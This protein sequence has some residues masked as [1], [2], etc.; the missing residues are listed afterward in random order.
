MNVAYVP[1]L[2]HH[3]LSLRRI[4]DAGNKYIG[5]REGIRIVFAKSGDELFAPSFGQLNGLFG[6]R[7]DRSSE[8]NLHAVIA[9]GARP[10]PSA[11]DI[12]EFHCSHG[13]MH[14][15]LLHKTAK[16]VG[17][18]LQGQLVPCQGCSEAKGIRKSVKPFTSTRATKPAKRCFVDLSGPK[19]VKSFRKIVKDDYSRF[20]RAFFLRTKDETATYFLKYLAEIAPRNVEVVRSDGGGEFSKGAFGAFC[21]TEKIRQDFTT[22][23][24]PQYNGVAKRQIAIIEAASLAARIQAGAKYPT[25]FFRAERVSGP[26]KLIGLVTH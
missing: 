1:G 20:T 24:S 14:E 12:N 17:V 21:T 23:D 15:N 22:A 9:P 13:H 19:S 4:A 10:T 11:A 18:K 16:Q 25:R 8:E 26:S 5:T 3:L 2:S 6:Y 7:T